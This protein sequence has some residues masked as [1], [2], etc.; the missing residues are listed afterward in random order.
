MTRILSAALL[1]VLLAPLAACGDDDEPS[2][3]VD[4][5]A[6]PQL[7]FTRTGGCGDAFFWATTADG[8][9]ALVVSVELRDR[10]ASEPT[11]VDL[12]LPA[13][14]AD[15][16]LWTGTELTSMMCNDI[17]LVEVT[18]E[19]PVTEGEVRVTLQPR[20]E[21]STDYVDGKA[22]LTGLVAEDGTELPDLQIKAT[23]IGFYAG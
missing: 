18:E 4:P 10:S 11:E 8:T 21:G 2:S 9:N 19:T 5:T 17:V 23:S 22:E 14:A 20:P 3:A 15:V 7:E 1:V 6:A 12:T 13:P 16:Q